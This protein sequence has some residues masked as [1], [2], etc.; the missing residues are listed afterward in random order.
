[1]FWLQ[2]PRHILA[3]A[4]YR[5]TPSA[6][7]IGSYR[8]ELPGD[9]AELVAFRLVPVGANHA[10][11]EAR[12]CGVTFFAVPRDVAPPPPILLI[13]RNATPVVLE[14]RSGLGA[15]RAAD[16]RIRAL[17]DAHADPRTGRIVATAMLQDGAARIEAPVADPARVVTY[18]AEVRAESEAG[19][20]PAPGRWSAPSNAVRS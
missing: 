10:S 8:H 13:D 4:F 12:D 14:V 11:P 15:V 9:L 5:L 1:M 3:P 16:V 2:Q 18:V 7:P 17:A 20:A 6:V 19:V